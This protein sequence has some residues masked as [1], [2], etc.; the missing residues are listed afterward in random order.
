MPPAA[1]AGT[2]LVSFMPENWTSE[3]IGITWKASCGSAKDCVILAI[4]LEGAA[5]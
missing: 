5:E 2:F 1:K 3:A 4:T